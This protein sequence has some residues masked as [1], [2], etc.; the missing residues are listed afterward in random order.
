MSNMDKYMLHRFT[1]QKYNRNKMKR[2]AKRSMKIIFRGFIK[3]LS[4]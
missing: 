3:K 1:A 2:K 4:A